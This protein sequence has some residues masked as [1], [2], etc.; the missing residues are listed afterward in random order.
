M[1]SLGYF[2]QFTK[3][4]FIFIDLFNIDLSQE[5]LGIARLSQMNLII[6]SKL[7]YKS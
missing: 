4:C 5:T 3:A 6:Q 7:Q 2:S 1:N